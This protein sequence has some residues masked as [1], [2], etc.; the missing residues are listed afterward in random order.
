LTLV[1]VVAVLLVLLA[2]P[3]AFF[4][5]EVAAALS[6][7]PS[8]APSASGAPVAAASGRAG[9]RVAVLV[10]AHNEAAGIAAALATV[11]PQ[12][13]LNDRLLVVADNCTDDTAGVAR[14]AGAEV[15]ER[16]DAERRGKGWALAAG[17]EALA[18]RPP[19]VVIIVDADCHVT[20]G[21]IEL[22]REAA[23]AGPAQASYLMRAPDGAPRSRRLAELLFVVRNHV[24]P[25]GLARIGAPCLLTGSGM[26]L[27]WTVAR[28]AP[29]AGGS[30]VEDTQLAVDLAAAGTPVQFCAE[31]QVISWFPTGE[32]AAEAQRAR[33]LW[34]NVRAAAQAPRLLAA[35]VRH[36]RLGLLS[37]ALELMVPPLSL[38]FPAWAMVAGLAVLA[39]VREH[40]WRPLVAAAVWLT[41]SSLAVVGAW[42]RF[43]RERIPFMVLVAAP[44]DALPTIASAVRSLFRRRQAWNRTRRD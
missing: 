21:A 15:L 40:E 8:A 12:L 14:A 7:A 37:L 25:L 17:I 3:S 23:L 1:I 42:A 32:R 27:P 36:S 4:V 28:A 20:A 39:G 22:L 26:A 35:A 2:V 43:A 44:L 6:R 31:A 16:R 33:W 34:G 10:P 19:E 9:T 38:L 11:L 24:R 29:F 18:A 30:V 5:L 41:L 13:R